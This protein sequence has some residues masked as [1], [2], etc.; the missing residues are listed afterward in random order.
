MAWAAAL[1]LIFVVFVLSVL[2]RIAARADALGRQ[3]CAAW[4]TARRSIAHRAADR[5]VRQVHGGEG[6]VAAVR[7]E[8]GARADRAVGMRQVHVSPHPQ[9]DARDCRGRL[10]HRPR[11]ARRRGH[12]RA[13]ASTRCS[14]AAGWAW[15][16]RSRRR[17][18]PCRSSTT[19]RRGSASTAPASARGVGRDGGAS[20]A[21]RRALGRGEGPAARERDGALRRA[22]AAAL[23]R[24]HHRARSRK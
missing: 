13:A 7:G 19:W 10:D 22:A 1:V 9:P 6:R 23:P 11:A 24:A 21:A 2:A 17:F 15:C 8:P 18:R 4:L 16:S 20:A 3:F 5:D 12:L 14:S